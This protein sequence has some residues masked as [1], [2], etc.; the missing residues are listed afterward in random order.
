M[1]IENVQRRAT[2]QIPGLAH[3]SYLERLQLLKLPT[4]QYRRYRGGMIGMYKLSHGHYDEAATHS[5]FNIRTNKSVDQNFR[6]HRFT[7]CKERCKKEVRKYLFKCCVTDQ[8]NNL[9]DALVE[10][11]SLNAF[12]NRLDKLWY[13]IELCMTL[14]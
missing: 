14:T 11:S 8:W 7:M 3:L 9:P 4:L 13:A 6:G 2:K 12:K 10:A 5:F 1:L